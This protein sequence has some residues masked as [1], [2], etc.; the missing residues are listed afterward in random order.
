MKTQIPLS[1]FVVVLLNLP[2]LA[3]K[4]PLSPELLESEADLIAIATVEEIRI[5]IEKPTFDPPDGN[6]DWGIYLTLQ[7]ETVEKGEVADNRL[8]A[9][10]FR[11]R[12][13]KSFFEYMTV[14]GHYPIPPVGTRARVYLEQDGDSWRVVLPN[15]I[16]CLD[17]NPGDAPEVSELESGGYTYGLALE[18]W[19]M[20]GVL[21]ILITLI[22]WGVR[23]FRRRKQPRQQPGAAEH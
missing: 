17:G 4:A 22:A 8:E 23:R 3:E 6:S 11:I 9:R 19:W 2:A 1:L 13:R 14:G 5:E 7:F 20:L 16:T 15:G 21:T 12:Q 18:T 10:C